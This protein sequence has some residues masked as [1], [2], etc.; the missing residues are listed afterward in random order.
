M[1]PDTDERPLAIAIVALG[2]QGGGVLAEWIVAA[3]EDCGWI[4]QST[5][6]PGV[7]QR[8]GATLYYVEMM[9]APA[10][11]QPVLA[12]M[13]APGEVDVVL[14]LEY[15]EAGRAI[16]R[17]L[18]TPDRTALVASTHR[19]LA[20]AEKQHPGDGRAD[21]DAVTQAA[22]V[23]ARRFL[24]FDMQALAERHGSAVSAVMMGAAAAVLPLPREAFAA[25]I[26]AGGKGGERSLAAFAAGHERAAAGGHQPPR[27]RSPSLLPALPDRTRRPALEALVDRIR[28]D[29]PKLLQPLLFAGVRRLVDYQDTDYAGEYLDRMGELLARDGVARGFAFS[30]A[31]AKHLAVAM[32][33]DDVVRVADLKTRAARFARVRRECG[34]AAGDIVHVTEFMHPRMAEVAGTLPRRL[35]LWIERRPRLFRALDFAVNRGRRVRTSGLSGFLML[36]L[37]ASLRPLRR[38]GLRHGREVAHIERWLATATGLIVQDYDLAVEVV[39]CRRLIKGYSDTHARGLSKFDRVLGALPLLAGRADAAHWLRR[40]REAALSDEEGEA[41]DGALKTVAQL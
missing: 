38:R 36:Y 29:F 23:A 28:Q 16:L 4:A 27:G 25:A 15:M 11:R 9:R 26:K 14:A 2:G 21:P 30:L 37:V 34:A 10:G 20:V 32:S 24:A 12:L 6:V 33:Y 39:A 19:A 40:L 13:P 7:A 41:L 3:A 22:A 35:G 31:A 18:V 17:G 8:T 5:S 1:T